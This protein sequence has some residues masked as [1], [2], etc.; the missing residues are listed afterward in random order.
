VL[1]GG[2]GEG[3][4][5]LERFD[6]EVVS[7]VAREA[8]VDRGVD[9]RLHDQEDVGRPVPLTAVAISTNFSSSTCRSVPSA[10]NNTR[11]WRTAPR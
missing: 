7:H 5:S 3:R 8:K 11:A 6:D 1:G 2:L 9:E 10:C 4:A